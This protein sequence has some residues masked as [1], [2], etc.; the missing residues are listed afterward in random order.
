MTWDD[1]DVIHQLHS[2]E[3]VGQFNT[4]GMPRHR[5]DTVEVMLIALEDKHMTQRTHY[6]WTIRI[7]DNQEFVGECGIHLSADRFRRG[8]IHYSLMPNHWNKGFGTE[9]VKRIIAFGFNELK[10]HRIQAGVATANHRSI[11]VLEKAGMIREGLR[12]KYLPLQGEWQDSYHYAI[13][14]DDPFELLIG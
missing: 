8:E 6:G 2:I 5:G 9:V 13:L 3:E 7:S 10:L 4:I 14:E 12:R 1:V 11:H